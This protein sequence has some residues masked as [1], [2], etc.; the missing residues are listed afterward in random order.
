MNITAVF[1]WINNHR[2]GET[3]RLRDRETKGKRDGEME[4]RSVIKSLLPSVPLSLR[5]C[6]SMPLWL[7]NPMFALFIK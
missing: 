5:L 2:D 1:R 6:V 7:K 4:R 3:E